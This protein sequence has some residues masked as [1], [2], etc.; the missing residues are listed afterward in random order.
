MCSGI[1]RPVTKHFRGHKM[2]EWV[3][4][5]HD[6]VIKRFRINEGETLIIGRGSE[7]DV[8]VD[9]NAISRQHTSLELKG[10]VYYVADLYSLNGTKV[11]DEKIE[12]AL[13]VAKSDKIEI[14]KFTLKPADLMDATGESY[15]IA[16]APDMN[17]ETIFVGSKKTN[18]ANGPPKKSKDVLDVLEGRAEPDSVSLA[19]T[20]IV[21]IGKSSFCNLQIS[22]FLV[23]DVQCIVEKKEDKFHITPNNGWRKVKLNGMKI[24][25]KHVLRRGDIIQIA[26]VKIRFK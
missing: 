10:G 26:G 16:A 5:L 24:Y 6:R 14:G 18:K 19:D 22:G 3:I 7:A 12:S 21:K 1:H 25:Q 8:I 23:S 17:D 2:D 9:N 4:T 13:P 15:S 20:E 11:N